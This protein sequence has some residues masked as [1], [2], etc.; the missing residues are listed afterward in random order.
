MT[1][2]AA[3]LTG[4]DLLGI[5]DL[6]A[7]GVLSLINRAMKLKA[8]PLDP[9]ALAGIGVAM[10]FEK[11]SLRTRASFEFGL[12][13]LGANAVYF[14]LGGDR[15]GARESVKDYAMNL[16]R[17]CDAIVA[18]VHSHEVLEELAQHASVPVVNAL[19]DIEH[20]CQALAD[21]LTLRESLGT[22]GGHRVAYIGE[23]NN[24]CHSLML[25]AASVGLG[26]TV[27][28]PEG[29]GPDERILAEAQRRA[30][31]AGTAVRVAHEPDAVR[32]HDAVYTDTWFSMGAAEHS[33]GNGRPREE[34]FAPFTVD[35]SLM[36]IASDGLETPSRFMHCLP[37]K[38][39]REVAASVID[40][41]HSLVYEQAENRMHAQNALMIAL[42]GR[43]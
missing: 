26:C 12:A 7:P 31:A 17:W 28:T 15:I 27:V 34:L 4:R 36:A 18:R 11:P 43:S 10:L 1:T 21:L 9:A 42:L 3:S 13:R 23:G 6:D 8:A 25:A 40:G 39:G 35:E 22:L 20:P 32:A 37:A 16:E 19:S 2:A 33:N 29:H 30:A 41:P 24:V 14:D 5:A 38:R